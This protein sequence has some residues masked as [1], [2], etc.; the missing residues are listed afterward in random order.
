MGAHPS[1]KP[2]S[3]LATCWF[4]NT[5]RRLLL[6]MM[7]HL[8]FSCSK[9]RNIRILSALSPH[10]NFIAPTLLSCYIPPI[11]NGAVIYFI[12][13]PLYTIITRKIESSTLSMIMISI[14]RSTITVICTMWNV[15]SIPL[16]K[17]TMQKIIVASCSN[18]YS[19]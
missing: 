15:S 11:Q 8:Q 1:L 19:L 17:K 18:I 14:V 9:I 2:P 16:K 13:G 7:L 6:M 12:V 4:S 3:F 10:Y 5:C